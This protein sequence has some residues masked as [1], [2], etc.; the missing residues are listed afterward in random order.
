VHE[1]SGKLE[2]TNLKELV[3]SSRNEMKLSTLHLYEEIIVDS[4]IC[5]SSYNLIEISSL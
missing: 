4:A 5:L 1:N 2:N 3:K